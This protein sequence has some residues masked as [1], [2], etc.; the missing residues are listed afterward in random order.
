MLSWALSC[1]KENLNIR[2]L[3]CWHADGLSFYASPFCN[4]AEKRSIPVKTRCARL[5]AA[6]TRKNGR[7]LILFLSNHSDDSVQ[8]ESRS[9]WHSNFLGT[10]EGYSTLHGAV[11]IARF[12]GMNRAKEGKKRP[13]VS[14]LFSFFF[15]QYLVV[16]LFYFVLFCF[17]WLLL[18]GVF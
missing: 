6:K 18:A 4:L 2:S 17:W 16:G 9:P 7:K 5:L 3:M 1:K 14:L 13:Q 12:L 11:L 10:S 15:L 8:A